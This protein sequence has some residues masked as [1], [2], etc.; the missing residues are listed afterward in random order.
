MLEVEIMLDRESSEAELNLVSAMLADGTLINSLS[1]TAD[2]F[3]NKTAQTILKAMINL[4]KGNTEVNLITVSNVVKSKIEMEKLINLMDKGNIYT[5]V[6]NSLQAEVVKNF[7]R[8]KCAELMNAVNKDLINNVEPSLILSNVYNSM[9]KD[10]KVNNNTFDIS[11]VMMETLN[12]IEAS[13]SQG[14]DISGLQTGYLKLDSLINGF[15]RKKYIIIA[16]RPS[17][18]KTAFSL[19]IA[20]RLGSKYKGIYFSIEMAK[21][22]LG[23]RLLA[24]VSYIN[25]YK[26]NAGKLNDDEFNRL[27]NGAARVSKLSLDVNDKAGIT[28]EEICRTA[29]QVKYSQ[30][31][32][33][34]VVD[35]LQLAKTENRNCVT[36]KM[37]VDEISGA[38]RELAKRLDI[39]VIALAQLNRAVEGRS[40]KKPQ[41]SDLK[42]S[43]N[44]EQDANIILLLH[45]EKD[46]DMPITF[47]DGSEKL[48]VIIGK[49]RDGQTKTLVYGYYKQT[50]RIEEKG[51]ESSY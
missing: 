45:A 7:Q 3:V 18:G 38:L 31:L 13:Y 26:V 25:A 12:E 29:T 41:V 17:V 47:Q 2:Y 50:Q 23:K 4:N 24:N 48:N 30:G 1:I 37:K 28:V 34:I 16:A 8:R 42:E 22:N 43:G 51:I 44:I 10:T 5:S 6:F 32:D 11:S 9:Q 14:G 15:E 49:N 27:S 21:E 46:G 35:Y 33:F 19:E 20:K 40:D 36:E 39:C